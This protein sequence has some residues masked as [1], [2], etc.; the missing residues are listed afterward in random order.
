MVIYIVSAYRTAIGNLC[1][2]LSKMS[3]H[4]LGSH[5]IDQSLSRDQINKE[6]VNEVILGQVLT[7]G[8]GQNPARQSSICA[9][10]PNS[11]PAYT[12]NQVCGSGLRSVFLGAYTIANEEADLIVTG[13]QE[14]MSQ[15]P[16]AT[17]MR[18]GTKFGNKIMIDTMQKDGLTDAFNQYAMG[19]TAENIAR[20]YNIS[21]KMQDDFAL[22]SQNKA[23]YA[24]VKMK[25]EI[26]PIE[27]VSKHNQIIFDT[28]EFPRN[29]SN[30]ETLSRLKP[31]FDPGGTVTAGNSSGINDGAAVIVVASERYIK[32]YDIKPL[33]KI[34]TMAHV[35]VDPELM[36]IGPAY[37]IKKLLKKGRIGIADIDIIEL[38]EAFAS[39]SLA[40]IDEAGLDI[41]K[42][43][44]NGGAIALGHP[45]G[46][47]GARCLVTL[48]YEMRRRNLSNG[49]VT[50]C[51]GG[52]M[53]IAMLI[54][55]C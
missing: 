13:G 37:A 45:L 24:Q 3:A 42:V 26:I 28:D 4:E 35:G 14:N 31:V 30:I 17:H 21:R 27:I 41:Q 49:L 46:A 52:G 23:K 5:L 54:E 34:H 36:G 40:V 38:N 48:I 7:A 51:I 43:N 25:E 6:H 19:I 2:S 33:A 18:S 50:L 55:N 53:G 29:D 15:A 12:V 11:I 44:V 8:T 39:Q 22:S 47:S 32:K 9:G 16:H 1:G 10:L 20:K